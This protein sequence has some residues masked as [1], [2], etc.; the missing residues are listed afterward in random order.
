MIRIHEI[1][2][3]L[4]LTATPALAQV[5]YETDSLKTRTEST[6]AAWII[7]AVFLIGT[8]IVAF[9]PSKRSNLQ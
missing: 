6:T 5:S 8:L 7:G 1:L 4:I 2:T 9:K 3:A